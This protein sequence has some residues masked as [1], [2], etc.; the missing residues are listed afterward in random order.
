MYTNKKQDSVVRTRMTK[1]L[2]SPRLFSSEPPL[3]PLPFQP[4]LL[5]LGNS[6]ETR[7]S[8]ETRRN[9]ERIHRTATFLPSMTVHRVFDRLVRIS[10]MGN[11][12]T[13]VHEDLTDRPALYVVNNNNEDFLRGLLAK[14]EG[15]YSFLL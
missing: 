6:S 1:I 10:R 8:N 2:P 11:G 5:R 15:E 3:D 13:V 14:Q 7:K 12:H 9:K 4:E